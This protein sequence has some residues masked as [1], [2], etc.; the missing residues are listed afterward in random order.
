MAKVLVV[1]DERIVAKD[2]ERTLKRLGHSVPAT[3]S[4]ADDAIR[5]AEEHR[6]DVVLMDIHLDGPRDG[7]A[8]AS[9]L[10]ARMDVAVVYLTAFADDDT[11]SRARETDPFGYLVKPFNER[12]LHSTLEIALHRHKTEA[13]LRLQDR[14]VSL[15]ALAAGVAHEINNP[16]AFVMANL[17]FASK[18]IAAAAAELD[19]LAAPPAEVAVPHGRLRGARQ[20]MDDAAEGAERIRR[21]VA[22]LK[23]FARPDDARRSPIELWPSV[24]AALRLVWSQLRHRAD[25]VREPG[26]APLVL[27]NAARLEQVFVNLLVNAAQAMDEAHRSTNLLRV[28]T[29]TDDRGRAVIE[30]ADNGKGIAAEDLARIFEPFF[31]TKPVGVGTGLG[32]SICRTIVAELGGD[33]SV[34]SAPD[35]GALFRILLPPAPSQPRAPSVAPPPGTDAVPRARILAVDD[36]PLFLKL[37]QRILSASHDLTAT[38]SAADALSRVTAGER[39]DLV[40]CDLMMPGMNG[41][42]LFEAVHRL[43][44]EQAGRFLFLTGGATTQRGAEF[45]EARPGRYLAKPFTYNEL[46]RL[47]AA[48]LLENTR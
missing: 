12:E 9:E 37:L 33:I 15:G 16:L 27:A 44:P 43:D 26:P 1:E 2:L 31:T 4:S 18:E 19:A 20:A 40:I 42:D 17:G 35:R 14:M 45:L 47:V 46:R 24:D 23:G 30:I 13:R 21:I 11:V 25:V 32:L 29:R 28:T 41:I 6:P 3:A 5:M 8:A 10:R 38:G 22:D 7:I 34:E 39:F 48:Q 36:E